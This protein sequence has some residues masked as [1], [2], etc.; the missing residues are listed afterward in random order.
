MNPKVIF[1][2][3]EPHILKAFVRLFRKDQIDI[4][5]TTSPEEVCQL[6]QAEPFALIVSDQRMPE[7]EGTK[8]LERVR[9]LSPATIRIIL[10][11]YADK[12]AAIEA[13]NQGSVYRFLTK[14]WNDDEL[15][16]EVKRAIDEYML[17]QENRRLQEL[18]Q[19]QNEELRDLNQNLELK[20]KERTEKVTLLN[21]QLKQGFIGSIRA[22]AQLGE[23]HSSD[24]GEH[25]KR[26]TVMTGQVAKQLGCNLDELFQINSAA[27]LH[28]IGKIELPGNLLSKPYDKLIPAEQRQVQ[29]HVLLGEQ[30]AQMVPSLEKA[31]VLIR[32]HHER[33]NGS[34]YPDGLKGEEIPLGSRIIGVADYYD[35]LQNSRSSAQQKSPE[36]ILESMGR[37]TG[38]WFDPKVVAAL[39][40]YLFPDEQQNVL[41]KYFK[42][43]T[44]DNPR[45]ESVSQ[46]PKAETLLQKQPNQQTRDDHP[47]NEDLDVT[48]E[49]DRHVRPYELKL[50]MTLSRDL[51]SNNG[52]LL[53]PRG[54]ILSPKHLENLKSLSLANPISDRIFV[55]PE[56]TTDET[57]SVPAETPLKT[58][59][60]V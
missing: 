58:P 21:Q 34:G 17:R 28:D 11:G 8:L 45:Q 41:L 52:G 3:D 60:H 57:S 43:R 6:V 7:L 12:D 46:T 27:L 13:I 26:V 30:I 50:G 53:L 14:P 22:M 42:D 47:L 36:A 29:N 32:H 48:V 2:D 18:T 39:H 19:S 15:R 31:A 1:I 37:L 9:D 24:L 54:T 20:V 35:H 5:T 40:Q 38:T 51:F 23:M 4:V 49:H 59:V 16:N 44:A 56:M 25:A 55:E 10:T 33:F